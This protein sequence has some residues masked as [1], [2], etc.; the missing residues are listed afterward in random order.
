[1][2]PLVAQRRDQDCGVSAL[3]MFA[4]LRYEDVFVAAVQTAPHWKRDGGL[5]VRELI[6]AARRLGRR[7]S[8]LHWRRVDLDE[9]AGV[10]A[11][12]WNKPKEQNGSAGHW[13]VLRE[14]TI[15]DPRDPSV[16]D[17]DEYLKTQNGR[18]GTLLVEK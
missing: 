9:H 11:V 6:A 12:N 15:I 2:I 3:A 17:A 4:H 8:P 16:W 18:A 1:M 13:V 10:L 5:T 7:L 14:G